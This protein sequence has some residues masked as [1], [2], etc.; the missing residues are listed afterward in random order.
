MVFGGR[1][2]GWVGPRTPQWCLVSLQVVV[3]GPAL[4]D[5]VFSGFW[6]GEPVVDKC[7]A[8]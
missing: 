5:P 6:V 1:F 8:R 3:L 7:V 2:G 4:G